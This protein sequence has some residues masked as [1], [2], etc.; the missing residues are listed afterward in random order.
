MRQGME[1]VEDLEKENPWKA[2]DW[3]LV[4]SFVGEAKGWQ[5]AVP[6]CKDHCHVQT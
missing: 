5:V 2:C 3:A 4:A 1:G 6:W